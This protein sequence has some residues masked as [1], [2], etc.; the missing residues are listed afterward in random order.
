MKDSAIEFYDFGL[1]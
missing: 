1:E